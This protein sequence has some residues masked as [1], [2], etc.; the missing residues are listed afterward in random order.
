[1]FVKDNNRLYM[2]DDSGKVVAEID[3]PET[4]PGVFTITHTFT[5][6]SLRGQ[7]IAAK[8]V[9]A[10]IEDIRSRGGEVRATCWYAAGWLEKHPEVK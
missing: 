5:D 4:S 1:M 7:G 6:P 9:E 8:L 3:Y 10:A 2:K